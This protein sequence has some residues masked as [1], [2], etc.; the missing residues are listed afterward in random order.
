MR[1][2]VEIEI[3]DCNEVCVTNIL[4]KYHN[5]PAIVEA[6][7]KELEKWTKYDAYEE[8]EFKGQHVLGSRWVVVEKN[9]VPKARFV[10]KGCEEKTDPR[11]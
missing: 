4:L 11:F 6:K 5:D 10:V 1:S 3:D 8:V 9:D 2:P 7:N